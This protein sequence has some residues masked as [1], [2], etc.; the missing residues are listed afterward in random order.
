M[1]LYLKRAIKYK[2]DFLN[3]AFRFYIKTIYGNSIRLN[4]T[5]FGKHFYFDI[6]ANQYSI[7]F[8]KN[9]HFRRNST[10]CIREA[11]DL[12][13]GNNVFFNN[14]TSINCH[15]KIIIG[16]DCLF[17]EMVKLYDHNHQYSNKNIPIAT[18]GFSKG[19]IVIG[20]NCWIG[21]NVIILKNVT[22]GNNVIIGANCLIYKDIPSN[23]I[24]KL[25]QSLNQE[26]Y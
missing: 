16:N 5:K 25:A 23:S 22:I 9:V 15:N 6:K 13:I 2:D 20:D 1:N 24:V 19:I 26:T 17:G 3:K 8:G 18:Q 4:N 10:V 11:S 12:Q 14:Y 7:V 21:S